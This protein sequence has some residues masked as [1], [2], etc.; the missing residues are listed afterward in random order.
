MII[1]KRDFDIKELDGFS[2]IDGV[3][4]NNNYRI[5]VFV[6]NMISEDLKNIYE[7]ARVFGNLNMQE[8]F[9][10]LSNVNMIG[11][12]RVKDKE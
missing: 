1:S 8:K 10:M 4:G 3:I 2:L 11:Y 7:A 9:D 6:T 12:R 5:R